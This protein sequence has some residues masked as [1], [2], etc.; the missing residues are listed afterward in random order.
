MALNAIAETIIR[1]VGNV[2]IGRAIGQV[3]GVLFV[4]FYW[5]GWVVLRAITFGRYP[6]PQTERHNR[7]FVAAVA[8]AMLLAGVTFYYSGTFA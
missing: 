7:T 6:P 2:V 5:L 3:V 8:F 1:V 4:I